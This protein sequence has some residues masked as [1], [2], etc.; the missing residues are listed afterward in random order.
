MAINFT[1]HDTGQLLLIGGQG[2]L[3]GAHSGNLG[4]MPR[5]S[6]NREDMT[7]GDG[8]Y[9]GS[10][11]TI[12]I[13]GTAVLG[14][15]GS[16]DLETKGSRQQSVQG[17]ALTNLKLNK[18]A[19]MLGNGKLEI[20]PY[21]GM[22][23]SITFNDARLL[24]LEL[25]AQNEESSGTQYLEYNF[26]FEA[27]EEASNSN[28]SNWGLTNK[29]PTW[30]LSSAEESWD[31]QPSDQFVFDSQDLLSDP[32]KTFTLT[33]TISA[34]G[35]RKYDGATIDA[36]DGHAW[37]QA[38]GWVKE[39]LDATQGSGADADKDIA[40]DM[41]ANTDEI[42]A[43]F[44]PFYMNKTG[45]TAI[46]NLK[47]KQYKARNKVRA[48]K[49]DIAGGSYSV[50]DTWIVSL[51]Q[52]KAL[53]EVDV[54]IDSSVEDA[55]VTVTV[56][57]TIMGLSENDVDQ[58]QDDKYNNAL[59]EYKK[60]LTGDILLTKIGLLAKDAYDSFDSAG[61]KSDTGLLNKVKNHTE[62][63]NKTSGTITWSLTFSDEKI[64]VAGAVSQNVQ[65]TYEN[66]QYQTNEHDLTNVI[67]L[68]QGGPYIYD[69]GT[70]TEKKLKINVDLIMDKDNRTSMPDGTRAYTAAQTWM[71]WKKH[72]PVVTAKTESWNP[73]T[74]AYNLSLEWTY[75]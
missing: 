39:R 60:F 71:V 33:H 5:F 24:S 17:L 16:R 29:Q 8:T 40:Q 52:I 18:N 36:S 34:V 73:K 53:H 58:N 47:T 63:H 59:T 19:Q 42:Q 64:L 2:A 21:G 41:V 54:S 10:R 61:V 46:H 55:A 68:V 1:S 49:S 62:S 4:P 6:I 32:Y 7:T 14:S 51:D 35:I 43:Q 69:S 22:P 37:R 38:A 11:Y 3:G 25:P 48:I 44:N 67:G 50:T 74:G 9:L 75:V 66:D 45:D 26:S 20:S 23:N 56:N 30:R 13:T 12:D 70:T 72:V 65:V 28:N 31:L 15:Y 57:G 27:Y